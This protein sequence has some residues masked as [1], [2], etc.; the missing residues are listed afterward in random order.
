[1]KKALVVLLLLILTL[2]CV[3]LASPVTAQES[4]TLSIWQS[5]LN[6]GAEEKVG[7]LQ[8]EYSQLHPNIAF[9]RRTIPFPEYDNTSLAALEANQGPDLLWVNS[10]TFGAFVQRGYLMPLNDFM[11]T[12]TIKPEDFFEGMWQSVL[13]GDQIFGLPV[14]TGTR[15]LF[16]NK[17]MFQEA[18]VEPP[19]RWDQVIDVAK[20]LTNADQ[21]VYGYVATAGE[22]WVWLYEH[23]GMYAVA[24]GINFLSPDGTECVF[25]KDNNW[26]ALQFW[27]DMVNAGVVSQDSLMAGAQDERYTEFANNKA[28]MFIGGHWSK[29]TLDTM[30]MKW[31]DDYGI[32]NLEGDAGIGSTTGGWIL[33]IT[34]DS[35]HP[36]EAFDYMQW[37]IGTPENLIRLTDIMPV[38]KA[39]N[40]IALTD[41]FYAPFK[42]VLAKNARHPIVL[43]PGLPEQAE[44]LRNVSQS[45]MLG[46]MSAEDA[47]KSFCE[48]VADTLVPKE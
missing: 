5:T 28:A 4:V 18:G 9:D 31:P 42:E 40:A 12:A 37:A 6:P 32:V 11:K 36:Q 16:W 34:K 3:R 48:Q 20:K 21:G 30:G 33:A 1:M 47:A 15:L 44:I 24:N 39:A 13:S 7:E 19:T 22:R 45:A 23:I 43:N 10:V 2:G 26:R 35:K 27:V 41:D 46:E 17:K 29:A 38:T 25:D 14:D 8:A